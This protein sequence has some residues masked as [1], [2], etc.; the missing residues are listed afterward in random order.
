V[1]RLTGPVSLRRIVSG[2]LAGCAAIGLVAL[3]AGT[4]LA[5]LLVAALAY[6]LV[7][8]AVERALYPADVRL[9]RDT[10]RVASPA[11]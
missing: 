6:P 4:G 1:L 2:P 8:V 9:L 5:A 3:A 10:L 7:L 11:E